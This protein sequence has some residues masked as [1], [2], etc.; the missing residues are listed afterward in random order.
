MDRTNRVLRVLRLLPAILAV[1]CLGCDAFESI[2]ESLVESRA[3]ASAVAAVA[4]VSTSR[5][6]ACTAAPNAV[7][8]S[9]EAANGCHCVL[10]HAAVVSVTLTVSRPALAPA[11]FV[12]RPPGVVLPAP[13]PLLRPPVV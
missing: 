5:D 4:D 1:W 12:D 3:P 2:V 9:V 7:G 8:T 6:D 11:D 10:G 13:E